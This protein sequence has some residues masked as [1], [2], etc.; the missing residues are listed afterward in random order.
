MVKHTQ[1]IRRQ[2]AE[3]ALKGLSDA[4]GF[5][6][7][8]FQNF[9]LRPLLF[10]L[11]ECRTRSLSSEY[12]LTKLIL[13]IGCL[14]DLKEGTKLNPE[15]STKILRWCRARDLFGSQIPVSTGGFELRISC[16]RSRPIGHMV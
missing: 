3:L 5:I 13:Q 15:I 14:F 7:T 12:K 4:M 9:V 8:G 1:A 6:F 2:I 16:I 10:C 11:R